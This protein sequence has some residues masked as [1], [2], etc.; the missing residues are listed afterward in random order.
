VTANHHRG[1]QRPDVGEGQHECTCK[2]PFVWAHASWTCLGRAGLLLSGGRCLIKGWWNTLWVWGCPPCDKL[3]VEEKL[4]NC[5]MAEA[6]QQQE[7]C[8]LPWRNR[9][10][11]QPPLHSAKFCRKAGCQQQGEELVIR[12]GSR[13]YEAVFL[14]KAKAQISLYSSTSFGYS[15]QILL[16]N[17]FF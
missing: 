2:S 1:A 6:V 16:Q 3:I 13:T 12:F 14:I 9:P 4:Q 5:Q 10:N 11:R 17:Y 8:H 7:N 15:F